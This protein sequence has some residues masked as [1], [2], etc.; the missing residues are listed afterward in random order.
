MNNLPITHSSKIKPSKRIIDEKRKKEQNN[1]HQKTH[2]N[3]LKKQMDVLI[4]VATKVGYKVEVVNQKAST[5]NVFSISSNEGELANRKEINTLVERMKKSTDEFHQKVVSYFNNNNSMINCWFE[6]F[7]INLLESRGCHIES[8]PVRIMKDEYKCLNNAFQQRGESFRE[9]TVKRITYGDGKLLYDG[10]RSVYRIDENI[11]CQGEK[12]EGWKF[13]NNTIVVDNTN[14][15]IQVEGK[16]PQIDGTYF[17]V[18][19]NKL[20]YDFQTERFLIFKKEKSKIDE[21]D[22]E[23]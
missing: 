14:T 21:T 1:K 8:T 7:I 10:S 19:K 2:V 16:I 12:L 15:A 23:N 3:K 20:R 18:N 17:I 5:K 9:R 13:H 4:D 6:N 11:Y 22:T